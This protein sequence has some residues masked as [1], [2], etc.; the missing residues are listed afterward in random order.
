[1]KVDR[2]VRYYYAPSDTITLRPIKLPRSIATDDRRQRARDQREIDGGRPVAHVPDVHRHPPAEGDVGAAAHL[3]EP[4][5]PGL[6]VHALVI[7][8]GVVLDFLRQRRARADKA[9]L[10]AQHVPELRQLVDARPAQERTEC[11]QPGIACDLE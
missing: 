9:H 4:G 6:H 1:M 10:A 11:M 2:S 5:E 8:T 3:P 7:R